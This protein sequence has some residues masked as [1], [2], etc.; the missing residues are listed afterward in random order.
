MASPIKTVLPPGLS[1][2]SMLPRGHAPGGQP[3]RIPA[4][5]QPAG[6]EARAGPALP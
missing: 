1:V 3:G 5:V 4:M 6:P 2:G